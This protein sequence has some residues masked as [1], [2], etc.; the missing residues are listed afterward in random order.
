MNMRTLAFALAL[1]LLGGVLHAATPAGVTHEKDI[2]YG[3]KCGLALT[4]D[5]MQPVTPNG[6]G[7]LALISGS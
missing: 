2:V 6:C 5:V 3:R 7:V 1:I 4:I